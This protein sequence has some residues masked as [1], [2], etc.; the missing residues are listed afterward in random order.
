MISSRIPILPPFPPSLS[1]IGKGGKYIN[2]G[3]VFDLPR[4]RKILRH[5]ILEWRDVKEE[6]SLVID[7]LGCWSIWAG[8]SSAGKYMRNTLV[9]HLN[10]GKSP[11]SLSIKHVTTEL[12]RVSTQTSPTRLSRT[13]RCSTIAPTRIPRSGVSRLSCFQKD[14]RQPLISPRPN[15]SR[16]QFVTPQSSRTSKWRVSTSCTTLAPSSRSSG[17]NHSVLHGDS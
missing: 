16:P 15:V 6:G 12:T 13:C 5:P 3:E 2:Y 10:L 11:T 4:L 14:G 8:M 7:N 1:H 9:N 17:K